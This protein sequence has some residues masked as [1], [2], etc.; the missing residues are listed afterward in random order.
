LL[1]TALN[2][3]FWSFDPNKPM[4]SL[5]AVIFNFANQA[6]EAQHRLAWTGALLITVAVLTMS[7]VARVLERKRS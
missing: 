4:A 5:P 2:N 7:I 1:F 6:Y 3:N